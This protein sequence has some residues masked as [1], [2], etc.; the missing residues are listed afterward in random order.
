M[1]KGGNLKKTILFICLFITIPIAFSAQI[2]IL[3]E[4]YY[5]PFEFIDE[6]GNP[7]GIFHDIWSLWSQKTGQ[8]VDFVYMDSF[9]DTLDY[10]QQA[11]NAVIGFIFYSPERENH[12]DFSIPFYNMETYIY[13]NENVFG[14]KT[15]NDIAG[16]DVGVVEDDYAHE[17]LINREMDVKIVTFASVKDMVEAAVNRE[18]SVFISDGPIAD[19]YIEKLGG[20]SILRRMERPVFENKVYA[21][22][23]KGNKNLL[24]LLNDGLAKISRGEIEQII[25]K[26][27]GERITTQIPWLHIILSISFFIIIMALVLIWNV[28]LQKRI[29]SS[30]KKITSQNI[31]LTQ[32]N[33]ELEENKQKLQQVNR[34]LK[35]SLLEKANLAKGMESILTVTSQISQ[36]AKENPEKFL[37]SLLRI[38]I[39]L[40]PSADYG[41]ISLFEGDRWRFISAIGHDIEKLK[42]IDLKT[43]DHFEFDNTVIVDQIVDQDKSNFMSHEKAL[44]IEDATKPI[45]YSMIAGLQIGDK[46]MGSMVLDIDKNSDKTFNSDDLKLMN[47]FSNVASAFLAM[48]Q[49]MIWQGKFQK[50]LILSM[51]Q[52]LELHD[53][54]TKG[55][56]ENVA[57]IS[58]ALAEKMGYSKEGI[59][60]IYWAGLVHDIGKILIP[61][62]LLSKPGKLSGEEFDQLKKHP[63]YGAK[64]LESSQELKEIVTIVRYHHERWD[65][66]GYPEGLSGTRIPEESRILAIADAFDAMT[67]NRPYRGSLSWEYAMSEIKTCAGKQFDPEMAKIFV[68]FISREWRYDLERTGNI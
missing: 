18:I 65:G 7:K 47:A 22:I 45:A 11:E 26:W 4:K 29:K 58:A 43:E 5:Y 1:E 56:S 21:A 46:K 51:I 14:I 30:T 62:S 15:V 17:F 39:K 9:S 49:Y 36:A 23:K 55:H 35:K 16:F 68:N 66:S 60:K 27:T 32:K 10:V 33:K 24:R 53:P 59:Q 64:V 20:Q 2:E 61:N 19:Y 6:D 63:E 8:E 37:D 40:I 54:Y 34:E 67:S 12:M 13:F 44:Q 31:E 50:E 42:K 28:Q 25:Q 3:G 41:S 52:I 57:N 38:L 48:Q